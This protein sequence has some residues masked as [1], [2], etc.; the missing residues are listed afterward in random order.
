[1]T[2]NMLTTV[3][4]LCQ[5]AVAQVP[6]EPAAKQNGDSTKT[7]PQ[8]RKVESGSG[9][10]AV[11]PRQPYRPLPANRTQPSETIFEFYMRALN[12][13]RTDWGQEID[14]RIAVL[15]EQS[16]LNPYFRFSALQMAAILLLLLTCWLW[17]DKM[18]QIKQVAA[19]SLTDAIN[20][21]RIAEQKA[22]EAIAQYNRHI[23][24]CNRVI[25]NQESG[26]PTGAATEELR[27]E[28]HETQTQLTAERA[29]ATK[30]ET[31]LKSRDEIQR[32]LEARI[33]H[34]EQ[35][36]AERQGGANAEL[37]A[38]LQRAEAE[39]NNRKKQRS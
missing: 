11:D 7:P 26:I 35:T 5:M 37:V 19:E 2:R 16:L 10:V 28:L 38:R 12:P 13:R 3:T 34:L 23:E 6:A 15:A 32:T 30:L 17:W 20:A 29:K 33:Q 36:V 4:L 18:R 31:D 22:L 39:L 27:R 14:R 1:M 8:V 9:A 25:E 24:M 21:K